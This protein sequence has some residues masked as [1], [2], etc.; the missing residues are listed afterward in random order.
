MTF[1]LGDDRLLEDLAT[2]LDDP[3]DLDEAVHAVRKEVKRLRA[4]LRLRRAATKPGRYA[5]A[6]TELGEIGRTLAPARDAFVLGRTLESLESSDG[7]EPVDEIIASHHEQAIASLLAGPLDE[8]RRGIRRARKRWPPADGVDADTV[9]SGLARTYRRGR[10]ER[11]IAAA[12]GTTREFHDWRKRAKYLRYQLEAIGADDEL[13]AMLTHLGECLGLEHDHT[14]FISFCDEHIDL[15]PD[16][17]DRYVLIDRAEQRRAEL[18]ASALASKVYDEDPEPFV[19][20]VM[21]GSGPV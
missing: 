20:S 11:A 8:V 13:V 17:R 5:K 18:R 14:V 2:E 3:A 10:A 7:W 21:G 15:L 1:D 9:A 12:S 19:A 6:D 4:H 16:R